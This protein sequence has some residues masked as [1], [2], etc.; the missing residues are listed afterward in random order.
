MEIK[1]V[2]EKFLG[3]TKEDEEYCD[4][5]GTHT[6]RNIIVEEKKE[7]EKNVFEVTFVFNEKTVTTD[8]YGVDLGAYDDHEESR[9]MR[10]LVNVCTGE[11][12]ILE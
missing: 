6:V 7:R 8:A 2:L 1:K 11:V 5:A 9:M 3:I 12:E 4:Y 10:A